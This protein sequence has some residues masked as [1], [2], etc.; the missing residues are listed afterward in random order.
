MGWGVLEEDAGP[1]CR[2]WRVWALA[3]ETGRNCVVGNMRLTVRAV[4][5][6]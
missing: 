1:L 6:M 2:H 3:P 5:F 4:T